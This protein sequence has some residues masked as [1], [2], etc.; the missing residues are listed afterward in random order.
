MI[1]LKKAMTSSLGQKFLMALTGV[2]LFIFVILHLAGNLTLYKRDGA[3]FNF[4]ANSLSSYGLLLTI[5]EIGL[6]AVFLLHIVTAIGVT[7]SNNSARPV[8]YRQWKSKGVSN[9]EINPSN[10]SSRSMIISG[11]CLLGFLVL[12]IY[13]FR[14]GPGINE[15]YVAIVQGQQVGD[16][17]RV[18]LEVFQNPLNVVIYI[19]A[20]LL[21]GAHLRHGFWSMFQSMGAMRASESKQIYAISLVIALILSVGFLLIPVW[22]YFFVAGGKSV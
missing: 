8:A 12:H 18:V 6:L 4:Y 1:K 20:M 19:V 3:T 5:A 22:M 17:H 21:L 13:Q 10:R 16:L 7:K 15:G 14:F 2:G 9:Q 11:L